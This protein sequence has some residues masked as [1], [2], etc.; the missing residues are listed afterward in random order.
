ML[1]AIPETYIGGRGPS[2][3]ESSTVFDFE[4]SDTA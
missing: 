1:G 2:S 3:R 4:L